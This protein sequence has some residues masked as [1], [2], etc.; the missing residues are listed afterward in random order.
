MHYL[1]TPREELI[2]ALFAAYGETCFYCDKDFNDDYNPVTVDHYIPVYECKRLGLSSEETHGIDNLRPACKKCNSK[3][4][5]LVPL[6]DGTLP[7][8]RPNRFER[9]A[10][11][12]QRKDVCDTCMSG[13]ILLFGEEC[14][15]CGSGP[16]PASFPTAYK[17]E[18][19]DCSHGWDDPQDFCW[20]CML[21]FV[22]RRPAIE[23]VL[24][25]DG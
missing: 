15:D 17:K 18:P 10:A 16:Q 13:R 20:F 14:P 19:K 5:N 3:K 9:R 21:G 25:A 6:E 12:A 7:S 11:K 1:D 8:R 23:T 4:A 22:D 2:P 24:D